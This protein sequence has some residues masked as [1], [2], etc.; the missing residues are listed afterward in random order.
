MDFVAL[1]SLCSTSELAYA[2][3][4]FNNTCLMSLVRQ[5]YG[6]IIS[7][8]SAF[9]LEG[10][11]LGAFQHY[12]M[13]TI[14]DFGRMFPFFLLAWSAFSLGFVRGVWQHLWY[15]SQ[16]AGVWEKVYSFLLLLFQPLLHHGCPAR[17]GF[18]GSCGCSSGL[19][20]R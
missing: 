18:H 1:L 11:P 10:Y 2:M 6:W 5:P 20:M 7:N 17:V 8:L 19:G 12:L 14:V 13:W 9:G 4:V 3:G 15:S 16:S